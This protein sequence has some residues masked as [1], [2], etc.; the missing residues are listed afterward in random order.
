MPLALP[1]SCAQ[2]P[3]AAAW[4]SPPFLARSDLSA[5]RLVLKVLDQDMGKSDDLLGTAMR[6]LQDL[7]D[8]G[9]QQVD[10]PLR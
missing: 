5:Q 9:A 7:A 8:G 10:L 1:T 6:G 2:P 3:P 4:P